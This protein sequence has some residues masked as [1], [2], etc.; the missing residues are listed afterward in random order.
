LRRLHLFFS[1]QLSHLFLELF[2][3]LHK[4][5]ILL[6]NEAITRFCNYLT[7]PRKFAFLGHMG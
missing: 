2:N 4:I 6:S 3:F 1:L 5:I 7:I